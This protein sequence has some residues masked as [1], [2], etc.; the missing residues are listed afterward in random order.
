MIKKRHTYLPRIV[1]GKVMLP[2]DLKR[3]HKELLEFEHIEF[4]SDEM[5]AVIEDD[6]PSLYASYRRS[7][8]T[9]SR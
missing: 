4:I 9:D 6:G 7:H 2:A 8:R 1:G 5:R 3:L